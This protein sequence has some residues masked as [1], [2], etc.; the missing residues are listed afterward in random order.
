MTR[1]TEEKVLAHSLN[2]EYEIKDQGS[3][4]DNNLAIF[5]YGLVFAAGTVVAVYG[6]LSLSNKITLGHLVVKVGKWG[7]VGITGSSSLVSAASLGIIMGAACNRHQQAKEIVKK[8]AAQQKAE[9]AQKRVETLS[10]TSRK[11]VQKGLE[12]DIESERAFNLLYGEDHLHQAVM[13]AVKHLQFN[14]YVSYKDEY[15]QDQYLVREDE[16]LRF[17]NPT[18]V[19]QFNQAK[20]P[21]YQEI[22]LEELTERQRKQN[23]AK[24]HS[25]SVEK[26]FTERY[27]EVECSSNRK[28]ALEAAGQLQSHEH[29]PY[30]KTQYGQDQH[31]VCDEEGFRFLNTN[32]LLMLTL[33]RVDEKGR[34]IRLYKEITLEELTER[35]KKQIEKAL[36]KVEVQNAFMDRY[37]SKKCW[38]YRES[39]QAAGQLQFN[40]Y[41][42]YGQDE[43]SQAQ[44]MVRDEEGFRLINSTKVA[45]FKPSKTPLYVEVTL[46]ELTERYI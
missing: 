46:K 20:P 13:Q 37:G 29:I 7:A 11:A 17:I 38:F 30:D 31:M 1:V 6:S 36:H 24:E 22:T 25:A 45:Q 41:V 19:A 2:K 15:D 27:G 4:W 21:L 28:E 23:K 5:A 44:Y 32:R 40:E 33:P 42:L 3:R 35:H 12:Y 10:E 16:G 8:Q 14:E 26:V 34:F 39:M 18:E 9:T 43:H